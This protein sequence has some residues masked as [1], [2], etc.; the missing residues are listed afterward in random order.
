MPAG[1]PGMP[2]GMGGIPG[3]EGLMGDLMQDPELMAALQKP[4]VVAALS[5]MMGGGGADPAKMME[6]MRSVS[7]WRCIRVTSTVCAE[8]NSSRFIFF[9]SFLF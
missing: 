2:G 3:M 1:F 6:L 8:S 5:E 4:K 7:S 9:T